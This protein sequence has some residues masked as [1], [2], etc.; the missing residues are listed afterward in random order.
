MSDIFLSIGITTWNRSS[1]LKQCLKSIED[2]LTD[3]KGD[4]KVEV[5]VLDNG[6]TDDTYEQLM[7]FEKRLPLR[8]LRESENICFIRGLLRCMEYAEGRYCWVLGDDEY[9]TGSLVQLIRQLKESDADITLINHFFY[10]D[11]ND[12]PKYMMKDQNF[13]LKE[14]KGKYNN[15]EDYLKSAQHPNAFFTHVATAVF[16]KD[17]WNASFS[18]SIFERYKQSESMHTAV[19]LS[20]LKRSKI[21]GYLG[22]QLIALR[23]GASSPAWQDEDGRYHRF[24]IDVEYFPGMVRDV[25]GENGIVSHFKAVMLRKSVYVLLLGSKIKHEFSAGFYIRIFRLLYR[26][27]KTF[28]LFWYFIVPILLTPRTILLPAYKLFFLSSRFSKV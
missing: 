16:K 26:H 17:L 19:L 12:T 7:L 4:E 1:Y 10:I 15:Y 2:A 25:F 18:G 9:I 24:C 27:Y 22:V 3:C 21:A 20:I 28:P 13:L 6:S 14:P 8:I 11:E 23:V 5:I